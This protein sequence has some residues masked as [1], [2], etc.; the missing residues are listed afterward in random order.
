MSLRQARAPGFIRL[1]GF[2]VRV[3]GFEFGVLGGRR[4]ASTSLSRSF[5][6]RGSDYE[7]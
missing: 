6:G 7:H 3:L 1:S 4:G 2:K 5:R